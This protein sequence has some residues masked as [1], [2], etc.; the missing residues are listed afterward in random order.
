[1]SYYLLDNPPK[2]AQFLPKRRAAESGCIVIHTAEGGVDLNPPDTKAEDVARYISTRTTPGSYHAIA[3][4]DSVVYMMPWTY[5]AA[6]DGTGS[7]A[8]AVGISFGCNAAQWPTLPAA[9]REGALGWGALAACAYALDLHKR[10]G[11]VIPAKRIS[12][13]ES[14]AKKPGFISHGERDPG[15]RSDPG[16]DFPW[17]RFLDIYAYFCEMNGLRVRPVAPPPPPPAPP[18]QKHPILRPGST[19]DHVALWQAWVGVT[20]TGVFDEATEVAT[21]AFQRK[22]G[23]PNGDGVVGPLTWQAME[24][25][26]LFLGSQKP[27]PPPPP[28]P[29]KVRPVVKV[30]SRGSHV[31]YLQA[32]LGIPADGIF[33]PRT[34]SAVKDFQRS[35]GLKADGIV[36]KLT[37]AKIG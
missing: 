20:V 27:T 15:R 7:N 5:E 13:A 9:W 19:G 25:L 17:T 16:K 31:N 30:G 8:W 18:A 4:S 6:Q 33:G 2:R 10:T 36:G 26:L 21:K 3:D 37:W 29:A 32:K 22:V 1:M 23:Y 24:N 35:K 14:D 12:K 28:P 11:I 34:E